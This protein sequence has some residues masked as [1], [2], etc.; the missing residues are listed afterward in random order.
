MNCKVVV[1]IHGLQAFA[2]QQ[3]KILLASFIAEATAVACE[4]TEAAH[5]GCPLSALQKASPNAKPTLAS[6][7][8]VKSGLGNRGTRE[9]FG[10][11]T[12]ASIIIK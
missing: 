8:E 3:G 2:L 7:S 5:I 4:L 11:S 9:R 6:L 1:D 10:I 12:V